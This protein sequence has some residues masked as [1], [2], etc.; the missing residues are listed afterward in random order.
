MA[1]LNLSPRR[2]E[3]VYLES[4]D[5]PLLQLGLVHG[6]L[7]LQNPSYTPRTPSRLPVPA[8]AIKGYEV[9]VPLVTDFDESKKDTG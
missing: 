5:E 8:E 7:S 3:R 2:P 4:V 1:W 6:L 9:W